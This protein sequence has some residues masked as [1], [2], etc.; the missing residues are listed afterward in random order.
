MISR[1]ADISGLDTPKGAEVAVGKWMCM[2]HT[3]AV[4]L[5]RTVARVKATATMAT[6]SVRVS[7][8]WL[9]RGWFSR[10]ARR[11]STA[12]VT[13]WLA[14]TTRSQEGIVYAGTKALLKKIGMMMTAASCWAT[15]T[16]WPSSPITAAIKDSASVTSRK[17]A[18]AAAHPP[19]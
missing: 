9:P 11:V 14:V 8:R 19:G 1:G 2:G 3:L 4:R 6:N 12:W 16:L 7:Q 18:T 17:T 13:G 10:R 5:N 15:S